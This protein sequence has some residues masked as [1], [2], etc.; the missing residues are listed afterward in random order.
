MYY[1]KI[2]TNF[3]KPVV[4]I[5][6][7]FFRNLK[8]SPALGEGQKSKPHYRTPKVTVDCCA[9]HLNY[10]T[11]LKQHETRSK[12]KCKNPKCTAKIPIKFQGDKKGGPHRRHK[13]LQATVRT[14]FFIPLKF[15]RNF[16]CKFLDRPLGIRNLSIPTNA[17]TLIDA[18]TRLAYKGAR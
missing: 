11:A 12:N 8:V 15:D 17:D 13:G 16:F 1:R 3:Q 6:H 9:P 10:F 7:R 4:G 5:P 18:A 14:P 2:E